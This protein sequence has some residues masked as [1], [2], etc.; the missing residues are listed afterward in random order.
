MSTLPVTN[1]DPNSSRT[2]IVS[3]EGASFVTPMGL[4]AAYV[5]REDTQRI[6]PLVSQATNMGS[7]AMN[8]DGSVTPVEF[9]IDFD[10]VFLRTFTHLK[11]RLESGNSLDINKDDRES[12]GSAGLL[13]NGIEIESFTDS[14]IEAKIAP[15]IPIPIRNLK[16]L[17]MCCDLS[18]FHNY[19][20]HNTSNDLIVA[21]IELPSPI[22]LH[23]SVEEKI[24]V[25][26]NDNLSSLDLLEVYGYG[27]QEQR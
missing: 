25:R 12:F 17:L 22:I 11:F 13:I 23:W 19:L 2:N 16:D 7:G 15:I 3:I 14:N 18:R 10:P 8:V 24:I 27:T 20:R 21:T 26:I 4:P 9:S 5:L 6:R 1:T